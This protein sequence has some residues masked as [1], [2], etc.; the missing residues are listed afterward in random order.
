MKIYKILVAILFIVICH[1]ALAKLNYNQILAYNEA[2][3]I[4]YDLNN[5]K[6]AESFNDQNCNKAKAPNS[7]SKIALSLRGFD[8]D[9]LID[10]NTP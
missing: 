2:C 7:T 9:I 1:N 5:K 3:C 10:E 8:R 4:L 6:I